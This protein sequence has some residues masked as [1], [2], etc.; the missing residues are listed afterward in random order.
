M[1]TKMARRN[2]YITVV[3]DVCEDRIEGD[4][5]DLYMALHHNTGEQVRVADPRYKMWISS[6]LLH[7]GW[8]R[9]EVGQWPSADG[10]SI[11]QRRAQNH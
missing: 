7:K 1:A 6:V 2:G 4:E 11:H 9:N 8:Q 10:N 5:R 3:E